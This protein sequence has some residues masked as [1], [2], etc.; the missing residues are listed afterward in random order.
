MNGATLR[1]SSVGS[2][3]AGEIRVQ[4]FKKNESIMGGKAVVANAGIY[5]KN[6]VSH[7]NQNGPIDKEFTL[8]TKDGKS[9]GGS[10][11][12]K[13]NFV[14]VDGK[15]I[16]PPSATAV[17]PSAKESLGVHNFTED[18]AATKLQASFR[19]HLARKKTTAMKSGGKKRGGG[20]SS[21]VVGG[22]LLVVGAVAA[23]SVAKKTPAPAPAD[24]GKK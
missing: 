5:V 19:G 9:A 17:E 24:K 11:H 16:T 18:E 23:M 10:V 13:I 2:D 22:L 3:Y 4:L 7:V 15:A 1:R 20:A 8:F 14:S 12:L 21:L 6:I